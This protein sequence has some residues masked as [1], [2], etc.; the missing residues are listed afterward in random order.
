MESEMPGNGEAMSDGVRREADMGGFGAE[1]GERPFG[2]RT[3][4]SLEVLGKGL[5]LLNGRIDTAEAIARATAD[6]NV[7]A[8]RDVRDRLDAQARRM[9][10]LEASLIA[11]GKAAGVSPVWS[12]ERGNRPATH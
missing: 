6:A 7:D 9:V 2:E 4:A 8:F 3:A 12:D 5:A 11:L 10:A 1:D